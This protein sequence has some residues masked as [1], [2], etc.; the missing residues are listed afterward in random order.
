MSEIMDLLKVY[1]DYGV[2]GL[3]ICL[4]LITVYFFYKELKNSKSEYVTMVERVVG[5][6][7]KATSAITEAS[8]TSKDARECMDQ[9]RSQNNEF[10]SFLRGRDDGRRPR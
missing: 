10:I 1:K 5:T 2:A 6:L 8:Q 3:F 9:T 7:D 4:Y